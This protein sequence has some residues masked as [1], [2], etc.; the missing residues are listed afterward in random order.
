MIPVAAVRGFSKGQSITIGSGAQIETATVSAIH[1]DGEGML[2][3]ASPLT[4][5]YPAG[6]QVAG[7][8]ITLITAL[9]RAHA[10]GAQVY[11][12]TPTPGAPNRFE[13]EK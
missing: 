2:V 12:S 8:G 10:S 4:H 11:T 5:A 13:R 3:L 9:T 1:N 7:T 6:A